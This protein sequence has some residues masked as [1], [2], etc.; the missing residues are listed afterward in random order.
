MERG[1]E[2]WTHGR[3]G[4]DPAPVEE[5]ETQPGAGRTRVDLLWRQRSSE[6]RLMP[7]FVN[8]GQ[9]SHTPTEMA[10]FSKIQPA[11]TVFIG[12]QQSQVY[13]RV[14]PGVITAGFICTLQGAPSPSL[15][16][17]STLLKLLGESS[18]EGTMLWGKKNLVFVENALVSLLCTWHR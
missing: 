1:G 16:H 14:N 12:V 9:C 3:W 10:L 18:L 7:G 8:V 4:T 15:A 13:H 2:Q 11:P 17:P 5:P 6:R